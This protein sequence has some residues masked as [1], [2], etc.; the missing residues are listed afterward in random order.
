MAGSL[1]PFFCSATEPVL[2]S[3]EDVPAGV[4]GGECIAEVGGEGRG[5]WPEWKADC[6]ECVREAAGGEGAWATD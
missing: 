6:P 5:P 4:S 2:P 3:C 1:G